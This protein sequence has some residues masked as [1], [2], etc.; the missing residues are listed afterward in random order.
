MSSDGDLDPPDDLRNV[1]KSEFGL[2]P[3]VRDTALADFAMNLRFAHILTTSA[4]VPTDCGSC[5]LKTAC[6]NG[7]Q[8]TQSP[9]HR[10]SKKRGFDNPSLYCD[11]Y[12]AVMIE[13]AAALVKSGNVGLARPKRW[14]HTSMPGW[15]RRPTMRLGLPRPW[16]ILPEPKA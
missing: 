4:A 11:G 15:R 9:V 5:A 10:F 3:N 13:L 6:Y 14:P 7:L 1:L 8:Q 12:K 2:G 16:A